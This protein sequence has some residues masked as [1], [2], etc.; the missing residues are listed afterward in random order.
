MNKKELVYKVQYL[1][2]KKQIYGLPEKDL[3]SVISIIRNNFKVDEIILF[4]SRAKGNFEKGSD[5]DIAIKGKELILNDLLNISI[6]VDELL[7]PY[8]FDILIYNRIEENDLID[9]IKRVGI[10]L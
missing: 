1:M 7:L 6:E 3:E 5:V 10:K 4:G 2:N 9:H 8:N